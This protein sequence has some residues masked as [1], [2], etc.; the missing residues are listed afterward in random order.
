MSGL[1]EFYGVAER[2]VEQYLRASDSLNYVVAEMEP[3][4]AE[5]FNLHG[6]IGDWQLDAV[7]A[8]GHWLMPIWHGTSP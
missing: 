1:E 4:G 8:A 7:P 3:C 2:I 6:Q 5:S